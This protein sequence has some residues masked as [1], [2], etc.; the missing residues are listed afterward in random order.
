MDSPTARYAEVQGELDADIKQGPCGRMGDSRTTDAERITTLEAGSTITVEFRETVGHPGWFRIAFLEDGQDFPA[1]PTSGS[2]PTSATAP[3]L[4][5]GI[6]DGTPRQTYTAEVTLPNTPCDNCTLQLIQVMTEKSPYTSYYNC[7]DL[8]L[9]APDGSGGTSSGGAGGQAAGGMAGASGGGAP[10]GG[11]A[12]MEGAGV[13]GGGAG[14]GG[15]GGGGSGAVAAG[16]AGSG[17]TPASG[18]AGAGGTSSTASGASGTGTSGSPTGGGAA[19]TAASTGGTGIAPAPPTT[20]TTPPPEEGGCSIAGRG[21]NAPSLA[22]L[23]L[24]LLSVLLGRR[25]SARRMRS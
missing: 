17:G 4:L 13:G 5:D 19:G 24:G 3:V 6:M 14:A 7:A 25:R 18:G 23:G 11:T 21:G 12:G 9:T 15:S 8:I 16:G 2:A 1:A 10:A 20:S 22:F